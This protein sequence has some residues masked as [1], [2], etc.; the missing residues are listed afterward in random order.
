MQNAQHRHHAF[1]RIKANH[2]NPSTICLPLLSVYTR[3]VNWL[4]ASML[5]AKNQRING[6]ALGYWYAR[7]QPK[8]TLSTDPEKG[9]DSVAAYRPQNLTLIQPIAVCHYVPVP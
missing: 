6:N 7:E 3:G 9:F 4:T 8:L 5:V 2:S 1:Y